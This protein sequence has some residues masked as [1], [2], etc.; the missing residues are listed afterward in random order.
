M[1]V[2]WM[3]ALL[4]ALGA[5]PVLALPAVG[6]V[7]AVQAPAWLERGAERQPLMPGMAV[8]NGDVLQTGDGGRVYVAMAEGS[9]VKLGESAK[10]N[11][12]SSSLRPE[13]LF[14]GALDVLTGAFRYT[15][16]Q[17]NKLRKREL[18]I[19]VGTATMGIR[20]TDVW[21][22]ARRDEDFI[23]LIEGHIEVKSPGG[24]PQEMRE[25]ST[26]YVAP[27]GGT[28]YIK[29]VTP[30]ELQARAR[31]TDLDP[32]DGAIHRKGRWSLR[33]G[34]AVSEEEALERYDAARAA[35]FAAQIRPLA[36]E[37][38]WSYE[39]LLKGYASQQEAERAAARVAA[40][41]QMPVS[42]LR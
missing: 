5:T 42:A 26:A 16:G 35:G 11:V 3:A 28:A 30:G 13:R 39:V 33:L 24:E 37:K 32:A 17:I 25:A 27:K 8:M 9:T 36:G 18:T 14:R 23:M 2:Q 15:T 1:R 29:T 21:G 31:E 41:L 12:Y 34:G 22:K 40:A 10:L 19:R 6:V 38:G 7:D 20:G 4:L